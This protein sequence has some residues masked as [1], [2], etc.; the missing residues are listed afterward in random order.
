MDEPDLM[1]TQTNPRGQYACSAELVTTCEQRCEHINA[2]IHRET[3]A[4]PA[5]RLAV[6]RGHL[7]VLPAEPCPSCAWSVSTLRGTL[8]PW[9]ADD[10]L[11]AG[12]AAVCRTSRTVPSHDICQPL[13]YPSASARNPQGPSAAPSLFAV[14]TNFL[15]R[16]TATSP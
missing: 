7:Q 1:P 2:G 16:A 13:L 11:H 6:E 10:R 12:P 3:G 9:P 14:L 5:D 4:V 8:D 15:V